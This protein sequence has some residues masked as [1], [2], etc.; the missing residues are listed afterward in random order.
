MEDEV[1]EVGEG[2]ADILSAERSLP[3]S[4]RVR[5]RSSSHSSTETAGL[6]SE[7]NDSVK[8]TLPIKP[9]EEEEPKLQRRLSL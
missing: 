8:D 3:K 6:N 4:S 2:E 5:P 1:P 9:Q 7:E